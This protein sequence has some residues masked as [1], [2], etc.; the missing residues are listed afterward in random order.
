V[1]IATALS[2][3]LSGCCFS[4]LT[5]GEVAGTVTDAQT[6][7]PI[8]GA[9]VHPSAHSYGPD[10]AGE[11]VP[12]WTTD[13]R[14]RYVAAWPCYYAD[15]TVYVSAQGYEPLELPQPFAEGCDGAHAVRDA[16]L[17]PAR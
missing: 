3:A 11:D 13:A 2:F 4:V 7:A 8:A 10:G 16:S 6:G 9:T 5:N 12:S 15:R 14:G 17:V 1:G